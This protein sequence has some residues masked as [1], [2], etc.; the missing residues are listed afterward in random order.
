VGQ[1]LLAGAGKHGR[2]VGHVELQIADNK[3][4]SKQAKLYNVMELPAIQD[5]KAISKELYR[6][7]KKLLNQKITN[8]PKEYIH[9][10]FQATELSQILCQALR[11]W[12]DADCAFINAGLLLG[13]L[14][15]KVTSYDLLSI[16]PH[17]IN[18]C[19]IQLTG[20]ELEKL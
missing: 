16:C 14:S 19:K 6:K 18:P 9:D 10:P 20:R 4:C 2:F 8:L 3:V 1:T 13:P 11:E 17:P 12:C 15:G 5:E 7:G